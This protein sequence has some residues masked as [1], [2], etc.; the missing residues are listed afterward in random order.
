M[1]MISFTFDT[2]WM[3]LAP[4]CIM[5]DFYFFFFFL[6]VDSLILPFDAFGELLPAYEKISV[7]LVTYL[8]E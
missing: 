2:L 5:I 4:D 8:G 1:D 6:C 3:E 7:A